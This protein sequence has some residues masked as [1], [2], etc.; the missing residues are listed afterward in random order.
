MTDTKRTIEFSFLDN[1]FEDVQKLNP[2]KTQ[3][4]FPGP[5]LFSARFE[6]DTQDIMLLSF[7]GNLMALCEYDQPEKAASIFYD[8]LT[9]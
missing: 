4:N 6:V 1:K 8:N 3:K 7:I 9:K 5:G 2:V